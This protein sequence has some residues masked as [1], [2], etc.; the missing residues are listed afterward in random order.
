MTSW[1]HHDISAYNSACRRPIAIPITDLNSWCKCACFEIQYDVITQWRHHDGMT[2]SWHNCLYRS[3]YSSDFNSG[4]R[5]EFMAQ[6]RMFI[7]TLWHH[8]AMTSSWHHC[9]V[10]MT[11]VPISQLV[12]LRSQIWLQIWIGSVNGH[13]SINIMTSSRFDV[14][15]TS[16]WHR[17]KIRGNH[18]LCTNLSATTIVNLANTAKRWVWK[19]WLP[20]V[21]DNLHPVLG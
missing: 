21:I 11:Y 13:V 4:C 2:S 17:F 12:M 8:R 9:V 16:S 10:I 3:R 18:V 14:I 6:K 7:D 15:M 20:Q 19:K 1:C 5:Y